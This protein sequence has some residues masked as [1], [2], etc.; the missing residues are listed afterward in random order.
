MRLCFLTWGQLGKQTNYVQRVENLQLSK[1]H[2]PEER[3]EEEGRCFYTEMTICSMCRG[4]NRHLN[5]F[6]SREQP[7][8]V[9]PH[10]ADAFP[11]ISQGLKTHLEINSLSS[12]VAVVKRKKEKE[13]WLSQ[14]D[15][16]LHI[17]SVWT[18]SFSILQVSL[19][20]SLLSTS[21]PAGG[22]L[23]CVAS[24]EQQTLQCCL[25]CLPKSSTWVQIVMI[26]IS[27]KHVLEMEEKSKNVPNERSDN[28][29]FLP[30]KWHL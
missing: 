21:S 28:I 1:P 19:H 12:R 16:T 23:L 17:G 8:A 3:I 24:N 29:L 15:H 7:A 5:F 14:V 9:C 26:N 22:Q 6:K 4:G 27:P 25:R 18:Y 30:V 13:K 10:L 20:K 2:K 11:Y